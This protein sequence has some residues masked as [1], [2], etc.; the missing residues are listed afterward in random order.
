MVRTWIADRGEGPSIREI[1]RAVGRR[2][3]CCGDGD[4][5]P[6]DCHTVMIDDRSGA[7]VLRCRGPRSGRLVSCRP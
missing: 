1:G 5:P 2:W 4:L 7:G 6:V 3:G